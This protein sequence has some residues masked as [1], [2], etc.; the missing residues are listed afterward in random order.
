MRNILQYHRKFLCRMTNRVIKPNPLISKK[1]HNLCETKIEGLKTAGIKASAVMSRLKSEDIKINID[2]FETDEWT[3]ENKNEVEKQVAHYKGKLDRGDIMFLIAQKLEE[4]GIGGFSGNVFRKVVK[5]YEMADE[6]GCI[7]AKIGLA[8][9]YSV[10]YNYNIIDKVIPMY[11][12]AAEAGYIEAV[13]RLFDIYLT[14]Q[15]KHNLK[16]VIK[17]CNYGIYL[18]CADFMHD[19]GIFYE[20]GMGVPRDLNK[21]FELFSQAHLKDPTIGKCLA[22]CYAFGRGVERNVEKAEH[23]LKINTRD[24]MPSQ[25]IKIID[26]LKPYQTDI[27]KKLREIVD[28]LEKMSDSKDTDSMTTLGLMY[29]HGIGVEQNYKKSFELLK[30]VVGE[31]NATSKE[32]N[33]DAMVYLGHCYRFGFGVEKNLFKA[34]VLAANI[35]GYP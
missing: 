17:L 4:Y 22:I 13:R 2:D 28:K 5:L 33:S 34:S 9:I 32:K 14:D 8:D 3:I 25:Y 35:R 23:F 24:G 15:K 11:E 30:E 26:E 31:I 27:D 1:L 10:E 16:E 29:F 18:D 20:M 19:M 21:A 7:P 12:T 6:L